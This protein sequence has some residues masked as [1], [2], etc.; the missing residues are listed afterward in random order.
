MEKKLKVLTFSKEKYE[1]EELEKKNELTKTTGI[2]AYMM[3]KNIQKDSM[4]SFQW[5]DM[6]IHTLSWCTQMS[7]NFTFFN[8]NQLACSRI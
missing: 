8:I 4:I 5:R 1:R 7:S 6:S 2:A 3:Q